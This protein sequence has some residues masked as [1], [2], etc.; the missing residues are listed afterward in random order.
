[1]GFLR[2]QMG[3]CLEWQRPTFSIDEQKIMKA[4]IKEANGFALVSALMMLVLLSVVAVGMLSLSAISIRSGSQSSAKMQAQANAR[5]ALMIAVGEVQKQMGPDQRI[6]ANAG[7]LDK[8]GSFDVTQKHW[9]GS[10][11]AWIAGTMPANVNPNYP[12]AESHHQT[13]GSQADDTMRPAYASKNAHFRSWLV[14]LDPASADDLS[15]VT[16]NLTANLTPNSTDKTI[17]LVGE[18]SLGVGAAADEQITV[19]LLSQAHPSGGVSGR[20][21]YW[22]GDENQKARLMQDAHQGAT[23]SSAD[24]IYRRQAPG[25]TGT[26]VA[27]G[28]GTIT[29]DS[30]VSRLASLN[31]VDLL[32]GATGKPYHDNFH[33]ATVHSRGVLADVREGGVKRDLSTILERTISTSDTGSEF[34]LYEFDDPRFTNRSNSRVPIQDLAAYYQ[35]YDNDAS[36]A[37]NRRGGVTYNSTALP[38]SIQVTTPNYDG[39]TKDRTK[40]QGD[41]T[42][43]YTQPTIAKVQFI[44]AIGA[45]DIT[46]AE[47]TF[48]EARVAAYPTILKPMRATDTHKLLLGIMPVVTLWNPNNVPMVMDQSQI[49][50][51]AHP[52]ITMRWKK[53]RNDGTERTMHYFNLSYAMSG[54]ND[55]GLGEWYLPYTFTYRFAK[56]SPIV[57]EPGEVKMFSAPSSAGGTLKQLTTAS[58]FGKTVTD[59]VN[60]WDPNAIYITKNSSPMGSWNVAKQQSPDVYDF[61]LTMATNPYDWRSSMV[62]GAD[63][64]ITLEIR[65]E[66]TVGWGVNGVSDGR[67]VSLTSEIFGAGFNLSMT[68]EGFFGGLDGNGNPRNFDNF[69]NFQMLSRHGGIW[70]HR[71]TISPIESQMIAF[72]QQILNPA[73]PGVKGLIDFKSRLNAISC[74]NIIN[75]SAAGDAVGLMDFSL[76]YGCEVGMGSQGG[77]SSGRRIASRPFLHSGLNAA[78]M[79]DQVDKASL[80]N[81]GWD[82]QI[83]PINNIEDSV[84]Q[85]D[86]TTGRGYFGGGYTIE[87]GATHIVQREIPVIPPISIASLSHAHLGG[88][89]LARNNNVGQNPATDN[90][91]VSFWDTSDVTNRVRFPKTVDFQQI[92]ATGQG[93][94]APHVVQAIGNSYAHPNLA[95]DKAFAFKPRQLDGQEAS[96]DAPF[97]DHSYL[98]NKA[99]W[100]DCFFSSISPQLSNQLNAGAA[101]KTATQVANDFFLNN[102]PLP[103]RRIA[104]YSARLTADALNTLTGQLNTYTNGFADKIASHLMVEGSFNINSTSVEAWKILFSSLKGKP[105]VYLQTG[106]A[107]GESSPADTVVGYGS[108]PAAEPIAAGSISG[109]NSPA[110]QWK[111][112]RELSDDEIGKLAIAM[113]EQVKLRGPFLSL[114][115]FINRRLDGTNEEFALKG[116]LQAALD[117]PNVP[118]NAQFR[119]NDRILD[120]ETASIAFPFDAAANGPV[121]YG[122]A[123]YVDQADILRGLS[124]QLTPRGD[125]FIIRTYGDSIGKNGEVL[126]RAWCEAVV[127]RVPEYLD[128]ADEPHVK[129]S[130]LT[131]EAN[132]LFGRRL[133]IVGFRWLSGKEV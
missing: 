67:R 72:N 61:N 92:T 20:Y 29:D 66:T 11:D 6:S 94:L 80:Y 74:S 121:A 106:V 110:E 40:F 113:V 96:V 56:T 19:P 81:Y 102:T 46:P 130:N 125:T 103:N 85:G 55:D 4:K 21:G 28:L 7:I 68:D 77:Y 91:S 17:T 25:S 73:F 30:E 8:S 76:S 41:Y 52:P 15:K 57:F 111:S 5:M 120:S 24:K 101:A 22:V 105:S 112:G 69:R 86:S 16:E 35:L 31:S 37:R 82:W 2:V 34:M 59:P 123:A 14:S 39:G 88:F 78:P 9:M 126:A 99:L 51:L 23:L 90:Y 118:I 114:S 128:P 33:A 13:L 115:E 133:K 87:S 129:R 48:T 38:N 107:P 71:G 98:A 45:K 119:G 10:W 70:I 43:L 1:M 132:R 127:L 26:K 63:D 27:A 62:F 122:S 131:S 95:A 50:R 104:P 44:M 47:R 108:L 124:E 75:A 109:P 36:W 79:I 54:S 64:R 58:N 49:L 84:V 97:V 83:N 53:Y 12:S 116:A 117:D 100:D 93:G 89:S 65:P 32:T 18:G 42:G 60:T 3:R